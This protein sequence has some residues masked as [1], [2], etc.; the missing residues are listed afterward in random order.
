VNIPIKSVILAA[1]AG[2][3]MLASAQTQAVAG[4]YC[5]GTGGDPGLG[6]GDCSFNGGYWHDSSPPSYTSP[7]YTGYGPT[8]YSPNPNTSYH[9]MMTT[10][11]NGGFGG[12]RQGT[13]TGSPRI[14][15]SGTRYTGFGQFGGFRQVRYGNFGGFGGF[16]QVR[17]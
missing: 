8:G 5:T 9:P 7:G 14:I 2:L 12:F 13:F 4:G 16:R 6:A 17:R 15:T 1:A 11:P 3:V 10:A